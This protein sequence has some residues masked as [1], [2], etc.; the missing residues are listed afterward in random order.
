MFAN[1]DVDVPVAIDY[2]KAVAFT[3]PEFLSVTVDA[4]EIGHNFSGL[5]LR[6][7]KFLGMAKALS[8][9]VLRFGGTAE[10]YITYNMS[11]SHVSCT[12][13]C[14]LEAH[15]MDRAYD[16]A[17]QIMNSQQWDSLNMFAEAVGFKLIF[18][19]N[20]QKRHSDGSWDPSNAVQLIEYSKT[21]GYEVNYELGNGKPQK[22]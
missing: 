17:E 8:P 7:E 13:N 11:S 22:A 12:S 20:A 5:D 19:L 6:S 15:G 1:G 4:S 21:K 9:A 10:D 16:G 2:D 18:G 3:S 14:C